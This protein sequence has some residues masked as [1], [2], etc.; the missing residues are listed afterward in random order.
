MSAHPSLPDSERGHLLSLRGAADDDASPG[1][2]QSAIGVSCGGGLTV[3]LRTSDGVLVVGLYGS[4][5][6]ASR[7][8]LY[9]ALNCAFMS[10]PSRIVIDGSA[11]TECDSWGLAAFVDAADR[12]STSDVPLS[13]Y[14]LRP[15]LCQ[16][17]TTSW[18]GE[19]VA[20]LSYASLDQALAAVHAKPVASDPSREQLLDEVQHLRAVLADST[21]VE[22]AKGVLM[23]VYG[24][25]AEAA[26]ELLRCYSRAQRLNVRVL[27]SR[28]ISV[29]HRRPT[30][31]QMNALLGTHEPSSERQ[32]V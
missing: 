20:A 14:G 32:S 3:A 27:A 19:A 12:A 7:H 25:P 4:V 15:A 30:G 28:V 6:P 26:L 11:I 1:A 2:V 9:S 21:V 29:A 18:R 17:L 10:R 13:M 8:G 22:Q 5:G 24:V 23:A 31:M 16:M